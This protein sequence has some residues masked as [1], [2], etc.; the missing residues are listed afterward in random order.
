MSEAPCENEVEEVFNLGETPVESIRPMLLFA[1]EYYCH[2]VNGKPAETSRIPGGDDEHDSL[3]TA[4][5][6]LTAAGQPA[7]LHKRQ[8]D[9][10]DAI[11]ADSG[12]DHGALLGIFGIALIAHA[13]K[14]SLPGN[15]QTR[16]DQEIE[17][18]IDELSQ[19]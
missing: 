13:H 12:S 1:L 6:L 8:Q 9:E 2:L 3:A 10:I 14:D 15:V 19:P 4:R 11:L 18:A 16:L 7:R 5:G 17:R